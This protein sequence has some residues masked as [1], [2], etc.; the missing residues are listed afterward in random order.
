MCRCPYLD[1][2]PGEQS[3]AWGAPSQGAPVRSPKPVQSAEPVQ[4]PVKQPAKQPAK[5]APSYNNLDDDEGLM[6]KEDPA[7]RK[8]NRKNAK[9]E[10]RQKQQQ[11]GCVHEMPGP[12][13]DE[14]ETWQCDICTFT[15]G[16][17]TLACEMCGTARPHKPAATQVQVAPE[18]LHEQQSFDSPSGPHATLNV[19]TW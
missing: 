2:K 7:P 18:K 4:Q 12:T 8:L 1:A 5:Q 19:R 17:I 11:G 9:K 13:I 16:G 14:N 6:V 10:K 3:S 15:N